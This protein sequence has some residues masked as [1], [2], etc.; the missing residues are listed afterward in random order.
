MARRRSDA[1]KSGS[2]RLSSQSIAPK[3]LTAAQVWCAPVG[4]LRTVSGGAANSS[5]IVTPRGLAARGFK[6]CRT[7]SGTITVRA[8]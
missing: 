7:S 5:P 8:Q 6:A 2:V 3:N 1:G 4:H